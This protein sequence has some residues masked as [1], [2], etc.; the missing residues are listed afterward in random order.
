MTAQPMSQ[1]GGYLDGMVVTPRKWLPAGRKTHKRARP[2]YG[3]TLHTDD[4]FYA[5]RSTSKM[6]AP[7]TPYPD[8]V[9]CTLCKPTGAHRLHYIAGPPGFVGAVCSCGEYK[10]QGTSEAS[11]YAKALRGH[12]QIRTRPEPKSLKRVTATKKPRPSNARRGTPGV[13]HVVSH[14]YTTLPDGRV[15]AK[16]AGCG[17]TGVSSNANAAKL[18]IYRQHKRL[19]TQRRTR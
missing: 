2:Q 13:D 1:A 12:P 17:I 16:C 9:D 15:E 7:V 11:A 6:P 18:V 4:C 14:I 10:V 8:T 19:A 5:R 3:F